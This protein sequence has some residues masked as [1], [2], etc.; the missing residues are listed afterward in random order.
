MKILEIPSYFPPLG[1]AF[2][3]E[4]AKALQMRGH[5]VGMVVCNQYGISGGLSSW[6]MLD[7]SRRWETT[8][9]ICIYRTNMRAWPRH[10]RRNQQHWCNLV[11]DMVGEYIHKYGKPDVLH[12]HCCQWA[13]VA[14]QM[15]CQREG[16]PYCIT[17]HT[18][19][20]LF[21]AS[22]GKGWLR[23]T[24]AKD[25]LREA[26]EGAAM[27]IP[28]ARELVEDLSAFFGTDYRW[29]EISNVIDLDF[30]TFK[31]RSLGDGPFHF[32]CLANAHGQELYRKGY[33]VL[34]RAFAQLDHC[35]LHI[36]G[37]GTD[38]REMKNLFPANAVLHGAVD[39]EGVKRLLHQSHAL[40]L[41]SGSEVQPLVVLEAMATGMPVVATC[42]LPQSERIEK[43]CLLA[44]IGDADTL[45]MRMEE[46]RQC[47]ADARVDALAIREAVRCL[48]SADVVGKQLEE[49]LAC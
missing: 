37:V 29:K 49:V 39:R 21:E 35:E 10:V 4:Q 34:S 1:G 18:P 19:K 17:E 45:A 13:G 15:I 7:T 27:V 44:P 14:A 5:E 9:G 38:S 24:W 41:A 2:S 25:L 47:Y 43:A 40:V 32:V 33:D 22:Y 48:A 26:Y 28:V 42:C 23:E 36:A 12:A 16:I 30:F 31:E 46:V 20:A 11:A 8:D 3:L 6:C